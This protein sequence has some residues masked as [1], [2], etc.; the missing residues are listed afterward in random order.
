MAGKLL[1][2]I[3]TA[4]INGF[5][6]DGALTT[7]PATDAVLKD[8]GALEAGD[9]LFGFMFQA[10]AAAIFR[11]EWR[12]AANS[13]TLKSQ[14]IPIPASNLIEPIFPTKITLAANERVRVVIVAGIT[15]DAQASIFRSRIIG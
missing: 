7:N 5:W 3:A 6:D 10:T 15:G 9:Y 11:I 8:T 13:A 14:N 12:N 1:E 4:Q 2:A